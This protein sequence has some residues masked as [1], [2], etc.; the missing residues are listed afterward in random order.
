M[1]DVLNFISSVFFGIYAHLSV[2]PYLWNM[3]RSAGSCEYACVY[4]L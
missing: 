3:H 4:L 1:V 2:C